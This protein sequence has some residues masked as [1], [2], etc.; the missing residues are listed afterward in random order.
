MTKA[1]IGIYG[2]G[3][4][5]RAL[6]LNMA[7]QGI[8]VA[9]TNRETDWIA[10]FIDSAGPLS[11]QLDPQ[12]SVEGFFAAL[13]RPR[14]VLFMI[15]SGAPLDEVL[16][17]VAPL[18]GPGDILIDAGNADF[19]DTRRRAQAF[20]E[21]GLSYIGMG[22]SGGET[23]ARN[24]PSLMV[25]GPDEAWDRLK[26][27]LTSIAAR[28]EGDPCVDHLGPDGAGHFVKMV[29]NGIEYADMQMI[30]ETY[31]LMRHGLGWT[32][33]RIG[34]QF[35]EWDEG[36]LS[37]YLVQITGAI[38]RATDADGAPFLDRIMDAAGQKGTGRW[39]VIEALHLGQSASSIE[40]A[41]GAR[42]WS[43]DKPLRKAAEALHGGTREGLDLSTETLGQALLAARMIGQ[44]QG[45]G[46]LNAASDHYDWGLDPARIAEIWRAGCII[47]SR[48]LN[49][50]SRAFAEGAPNGALLLAPSYAKRLIALIPALRDTVAASARAGHPAPALSAALGWYDT[51]RQ[52]R[53]TADLIQAQ[54]DFFGRHGF[55]MLNHDG[56]HHGPWWD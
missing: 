9:V 16:D 5:G 37:S 20:G 49:D 7:D 45:F 29:H 12:E 24:G 21:R 44:A 13:E 33:D 34:A 55:E 53:G 26:P 18:M 40:A 36:P 31:G 50:I 2:L 28:Y 35:A 8:R 52:G 6:A 42:I 38:L 43:A 23:G 54:R 3:T 10:G 47:R 51:M 48:L 22:V 30:A 25:G 41:V 14:A 11:A 15:P 56:Q 19:H 4:M 1:Q 32:P 39:T 17:K 27:L 46:I